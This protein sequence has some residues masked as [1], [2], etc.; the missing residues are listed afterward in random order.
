[1]LQL[2]SN[3]YEAGKVKNED[4]TWKVWVKQRG[5]TAN[6]NRYNINICTNTYQTMF[7]PS[8]EAVPGLPISILKDYEMDLAVP[9]RNTEGWTCIRQ[10]LLW[11]S[12]LTRH[13]RAA[14][15]EYRRGKERKREKE[16]E[17][18]KM[19]SW[20]TGSSR[21][22]PH[23]GITPA[24]STE[25]LTARGKTRADAPVSAGRVARKWM[26]RQDRGW[27]GGED[28]GGEWRKGRAKGIGSVGEKRGFWN[29]GN[30]REWGWSEKSEEG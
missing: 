16:K 17:R 28:E 15:S 7:R 23:C 9:G 12:T 24:W 10:N 4:S 20:E 6:V 14:T 5:K 1:M 8:A 21:F 18:E 22:T 30:V 2:I 3:N 19:R 11:S 25:K 26:G 13:A 27:W 29:R